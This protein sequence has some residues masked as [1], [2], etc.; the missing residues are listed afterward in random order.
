MQARIALQLL[1]PVLLYWLLPCTW[2]CW[3]ALSALCDEP[4]A[5]DPATEYLRLAMR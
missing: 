2:T 1:L 4:L 3:L 5:R